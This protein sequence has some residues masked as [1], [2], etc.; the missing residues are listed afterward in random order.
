MPDFTNKSVVITGGG[1][2]IGRA[3]SVLFARLGAWVHIIELNEANA[4]QAMK[5]IEAIDGKV[6]AHICDV[7]DQQQVADVFKKIETVDVLVNSAGVGHIGK[8]DTTNEN[9]FDRSTS[10]G[11]IIAYMKP[12]R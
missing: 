8:A 1:S 9:D 3:A 4:Q 12:S 5:E 10:R 7:S 11:S 2:G 6:I